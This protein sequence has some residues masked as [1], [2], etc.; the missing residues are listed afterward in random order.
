MTA[1]QGVHSI[2]EMES[3]VRGLDA[4]IGEELH[5]PLVRGDGNDHKKYAVAMMKDGYIVGHLPWSMS[6][7]VFVCAIAMH[8]C[9]ENYAS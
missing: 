4:V 5:V 8:M 7:Y 6:L 1:N 9:K 3:V 2:Y